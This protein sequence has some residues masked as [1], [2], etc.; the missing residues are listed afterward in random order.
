MTEAEWR[1][2]KASLPPGWTLDEESESLFDERD[3]L[4]LR[5]QGDPDMFRALVADAIELHGKQ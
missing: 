1:K 4:V 2:A 5:W 3:M